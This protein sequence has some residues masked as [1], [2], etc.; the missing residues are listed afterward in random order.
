[1]RHPPRMWWCVPGRRLTAG[2]WRSAARRRGSGRAR[3]PA[4][5][6]AATRGDQGRA[7]GRHTAG[8]DPRP[9]VMRPER[10]DVVSSQNWCV[11]V[12]VNGWARA[13]QVG[14]RIEQGLKADQR[15]APVARHEAHHGGEVTAGAVPHDRQPLRV[16][17]PAVG[18]SR[19]VNQDGV[20]VL[21]RRRP[22]VSR[23]QP[24]VHGN[25]DTVH[26]GCDIA[27]QPVRLIQ[28]PQHP[29]PAVE[30]HHQRQNRFTGTG[31]T[32]D[33]DR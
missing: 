10:H 24:V 6:P 18:S 8:A 14:R 1:M 33:T 29:T 30:V 28:R 13:R 32:V 17:E 2:P 4:P 22:A 15:P 19:G 20:A 23:R 9:Q 31:W 25:N 12:L 5:G 21:G 11:G 7:T 16:R 27:A 3:L 26:G